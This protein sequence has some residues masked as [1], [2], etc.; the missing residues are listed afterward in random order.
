MIIII[1]IAKNVF[2]RFLMITLLFI[3]EEEGI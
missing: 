3:C 2:M 1:T